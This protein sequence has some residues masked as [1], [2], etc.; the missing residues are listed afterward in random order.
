V[1]VSKGPQQV[2]VPSVVGSSF[3]SATSA[4]QAKNFAVARGPDVDS[5]QPKGTVVNQSPAGGTLQNPGTTITLSVSKGPKTSTVP[6][7][8]TLTQRDAQTQ[9][10]ASGFKVSIVTQD[11]SDPSQDGIVQTQDPPGGSQAPQ[12]TTVTIAVGKF[13]GTTT[14][15]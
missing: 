13:T 1:Q 12:G 5:N 7:V 9:L 2:V 6:D 14:P 4:L 10:K 15:R 11:V 3:E 8:T